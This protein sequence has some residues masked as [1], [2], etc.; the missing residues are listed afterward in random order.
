MMARI[1]LVVAVAAC[2]HD[3]AVGESSGVL[4]GAAV[5]TSMAD[6]ASR[7]AGFTQ[8]EMLSGRHFDLHRIFR[9]WRNAVPGDLEQWT[10]ANG[11]TPII[12]F[13]TDETTDPKW[14]DLAAGTEDKQLSMIAAGYAGL[15]VPVF[16]IFDQSPE[17]NTP[18]FGTPDDFVAAYRHIVQTFR[19]AGATNVAWIFNLKSPSFPGR[20]D[21]F[22]PGD[23]VIDWIG[24]AAYN[25]GINNEGGRWEPFEN[26]IAGFIDWS[27]PHG[28]P[29]FVSEWASEEDLSQPGRK[30]MWIEDAKEKII[31]H[32][33]EVRAMSAQW[34]EAN[35]LAFDSSPSSL[36]A[37]R[38]FAADPYTHLRP[39][40]P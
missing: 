28:K 33:P 24:V 27:K 29:L 5:V 16:G 32:F 21:Q 18:D 31:H 2:Q 3:V 40:S 17:N 19:T 36:D 20:A 10:I 23:D 34:V 38:A 6:I 9:N 7:E 4:F 22:Y 26:L 13:R 1:A 35:T 25:F 15:G 8:A 30:G 37:F 11:R 14:A 12:S 39:D